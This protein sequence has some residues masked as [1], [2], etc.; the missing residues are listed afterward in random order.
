MPYDYN[1]EEDFYK[2]LSRSLREK[3]FREF[4]NL[5]K[6]Q[7]LKNELFN[8]LK[9][10]DRFEI[11]STLLMDTIRD[12]SE[13]YETSALGDFIEILRFF[14]DY[15]LMERQLE[16][17]DYILL[18]DFKNDKIF[19]SNLCD[20]FGKISNSFIFY[21]IKDI[22]HHFY[23]LFI[24]NPNPY[25]T[26]SEI[27]IYYIKN[28]FF[29]QYTIYGLSVRY[30]GPIEKFLGELR[31]K[32]DDCNTQNIQE[33]FIELDIKYEL[34]EFYNNY[35]VPQKRV[36]IK[37]HLVSPKNVLGYNNRF[38]QEKR[39]RMYRFYNLSMVLLGGLGPQGQGFS[40]S[41][42][43]G[44]VIEICSD[45]KENEA[46]IVKYRLFLKEQFIT[47]LEI[48][49]IYID[50]QLKNNII[51]FLNRVITPEELIGYNKIDF[52][53]NQIKNFLINLDDLRELNNFNI[54][55]LIDKISSA[56]SIILRPI[57]MV[58]QFKARMDL[59]SKEQLKSEDI[60]KLTSLKNK[61]HY[62]V[63]RERL[64]FQYI[65]DFFYEIYKKNKGI[66]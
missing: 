1:F 46:I 2:K 64:F 63:L 54:N 60:A 22:P 4:G 13:G 56:I 25:F 16:E 10:E 47:R 57:N 32:I 38:F 66:K 14:N 34:P 35:G 33:D 27:L 50:S 41:T 59:V 3:D 43:R 55:E 11:L 40:Y 24:N 39:Y 6:S 12:V 36:I 49:L 51:N 44:E 65:V 29:N 8:P 17:E 37:R 58:D 52:L 45:I 61:S 53:L 19:I 26:D 5:T 42:P 30:L 15:N 9:I 23:N 28:V 18:E 7:N 62:D 21:I 20:L 31:K 48:E